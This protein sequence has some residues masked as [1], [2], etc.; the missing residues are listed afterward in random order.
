MKVLERQTI[1]LQ[2]ADVIRQPITFVNKLKLGTHTASERSAGVHV[3][4]VLKY[5]AVNTG[6]LQEHDRDFDEEFPLQMA[7][8]MAM[9]SWFQALWPGLVWQPGELCLDGVYGSPDGMSQYDGQLEHIKG[10]PM[11]EEF[12]LTWKSSR[13]RHASITGEW[14][15]MRQLMCYCLMMGTQLGRLHVVWVNGGWQ[16]TYKLEPTYN[17]YLIQFDEKE[18]QQFW[19][20]VVLKNKH[21]AKAEG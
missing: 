18:M 20:N 19:L 12:K 11:V 2:L 15:W 10:F 6:T 21:M 1:Q 4:G 8:G 3:S 13:N 5:V 14:L 17:T 7:L 9:E 16:D